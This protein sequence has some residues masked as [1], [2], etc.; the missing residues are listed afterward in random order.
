MKIDLNGKWI[1]NSSTYKN[2]ITDIPGSVLSALLEH[3]LIED[4]YY[5]LNEYEIKKISYEDFDFERDFSL[6]KAQ[7]ENHNFL[8]SHQNIIFSNKH[9]P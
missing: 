5:R 2:I 8:F 9:Y 1:I 7:L 3:K 6:S 4:P